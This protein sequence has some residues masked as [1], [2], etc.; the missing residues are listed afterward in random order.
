M[1]VLKYGSYAHTLVPIVEMASE[2]LGAASG[3]RQATRR[4]WTIRGDLFGTQG[5][6]KTAMDAL[7]AAYASDGEDLTLYKND[8]VNILDQLD[9]SAAI[10]GTRVTMRPAFPEGKGAEFATRRTYTIVVEAVFLGS[11]L[12]THGHGSLKRADLLQPDGT[13][14]VTVSGE[15]TA[16]TIANARTDAASKKLAGMLVV[17]ER[18][19]EDVD[20]KSVSFTYEYIDSAES[21]AV[22]SFS[23]SV[24][25]QE[26]SV[27]TVYREVLDGGTATKQT[28]TGRPAVGRQSGRAVGRTAYPTPPAKVWSATYLTSQPGYQKHGPRRLAEGLTDYAISWDWTFM[29]PTTPSFPDPGVP[30]E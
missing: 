25:L 5:E 7:V 30:P 19:D 29:F 4:T 6:L 9:S 23:E 20:A 3:A 1:T 12:F 10:H 26:V 2:R 24:E 8:G 17:S 13:A 27:R 14:L 22:I 18:T 11:G 16:D 21:R 28:T 15:V